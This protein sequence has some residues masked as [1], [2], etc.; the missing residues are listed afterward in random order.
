MGLEQTSAIAMELRNGS[1][2]LQIDV[3]DTI[4]IMIS[5]FTSSDVIW[6]K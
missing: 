6:I 4:G 2:D 5:V 3:F 1:V